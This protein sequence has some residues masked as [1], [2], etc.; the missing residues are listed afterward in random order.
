MKD[1]RVMNAEYADAH[2]SELG[3]PGDIKDEDQ[4]SKLLVEALQPV[5][6]DLKN[7]FEGAVSNMSTLV[8]TILERR[9]RME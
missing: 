1:G 3:F 2:C 6:S 9:S 7:N 8:S 5:I 4:A